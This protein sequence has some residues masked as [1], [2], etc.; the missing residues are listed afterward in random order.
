MREVT[1]IVLK[2]VDSELRMGD[3]AR[4]DAWMRALDVTKEPITSLV[5]WLTITNP[6]KHYLRERP[7]FYDRVKQ[8]LVDRGEGPDRIKGL[9]VGLK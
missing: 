4:V 5:A 1:D 6:V 9:L 7:R 2:K 3:Y 8:E